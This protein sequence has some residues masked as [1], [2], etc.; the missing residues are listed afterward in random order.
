MGK[1]TR[2]AEG[3]KERTKCVHDPFVLSSEV[4]R[5]LQLVIHWIALSIRKEYTCSYQLYRGRTIILVLIIP[6]YIICHRRRVRRGF[7]AR[8]PTGKKL[9]EFN[10]K[11]VENP[12][13]HN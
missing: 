10:E 12:A 3:D 6:V 13:Y 7:V 2:Q 8:V 11:L 5:H 9:G 4:C 1:L